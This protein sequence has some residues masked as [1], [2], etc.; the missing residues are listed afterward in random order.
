M[1]KILIVDDDDELRSNLSVVLGEIG[2]DTETAPSGSEAVAKA[3]SNNF[4]IALLDLMMP[5]TSGMDVLAELRKITPRTRVIVITAFASTDT[6]V[7]AM[8]K[9]ASDY[10]A[11]PFTVENLDITIKKTLEEARFTQGVKQLGLDDTFGALSNSIRR[12][13]MKMLDLHKGMRLVELRKA[14]E[15]EDHTKVL[16]HLKIL[17]EAGLVSQENKTYVLTKE[18]K[19]I[20]HAV[21]LLENQFSQ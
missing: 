18:G 15:I 16:F 11:K 5:E 10:I 6:A 13:I 12:E 14:L 3:V 21:R 1:R 4:D 19:E 20:L 8:K 2:Y 7:E 17:R 9:G